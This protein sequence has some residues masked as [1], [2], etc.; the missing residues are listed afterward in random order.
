MFTQIQSGATH[1]DV[2]KSIYKVTDDSKMSKVFFRFAVLLTNPSQKNNAFEYLDK[3][4]SNDEGKI[5]V[6]IMRNIDTNHMSHHSLN[7]IDTMM[8]QKYLSA[9]RAET[10]KIERHYILLIAMYTM[11]T[12][13]FLMIPLISNMIESARQ[14]FQ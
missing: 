13:I 2:F 4:Y 5:F 6:D 11:L 8:F 12:T 7:N 1:I 9:L 14:V 10:K 3:M